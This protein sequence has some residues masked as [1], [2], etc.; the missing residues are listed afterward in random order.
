MSL[1]SY[2]PLADK[3][4]NWIGVSETIVATAINGC[5]FALLSGQPLTIIGVTGPI[6]VFE[7]NL[8]SVSKR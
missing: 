1:Y 2:F 6:L 8:Y 7:E 3:T 4:E 5:I